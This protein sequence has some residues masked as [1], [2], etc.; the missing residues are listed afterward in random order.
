VMPKTK[1]SHTDETGK[2]YVIEA[3]DRALQLLE[4]LAEEPHLGVT[5]IAQRLGV[6]KALVF[7]LLYTL[8]RRDYVSRDAKHRTNTLG[9]RLLHLAEKVEESDLIISQT[10]ALM[11]ELSRLSREDVN[12][13]VRVGLSALCVATRPS[14]HQVRMFAEVGRMNMIH[15]G[16]SSTVLLAYA[17]EAIQE[18]VLAS[19]LRLYTPATLTKPAELRAR[20]R[21]VRQ[22]GYFVARG[23]VDESG[24]SIGAPVFGPDGTIVAAVSVAGALSRLNPE[25]EKHHLQ[26]TQKHATQMTQRLAGRLSAGVR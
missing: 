25:S 6:S 26:I 5:A 19:E 18:A 21:K 1:P 17:P 10:K 2:R 14:P 15:A 9:Y 22:E 16:G 12:L 20:L 4:L 11:D 8:E 24:F 3:A 13:F 23:D 7:R